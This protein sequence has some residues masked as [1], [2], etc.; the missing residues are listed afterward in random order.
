MCWSEFGRHKENGHGEG[1]KSN[2]G[3]GE[4]LGESTADEV[5]DAGVWGGGVSVSPDRPDRAWNQTEDTDLLCL[6]PSQCGSFAYRGSECV[7]VRP[8]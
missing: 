7:L 4:R 5:R 8:G 1:S 6:S 3:F 2:E